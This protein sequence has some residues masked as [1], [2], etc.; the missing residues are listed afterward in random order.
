MNRR[1]AEPAVINALDAEVATIST[2]DLKGIAH[3][4]QNTGR[5]R[6]FVRKRSRTGGFLILLPIRPVP[7][8]KRSRAL[9]LASTKQ[10][11]RNPR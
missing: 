7:F 1:A 3:T 5:V 9:Q 6:V 11:R 4:G 2:V 10:R 8:Q